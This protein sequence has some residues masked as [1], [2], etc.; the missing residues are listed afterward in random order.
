MEQQPK[1]SS[2]ELDPAEPARVGTA[3]AHRE[4]IFVFFSFR[5]HRVK[6]F[7]YSKEIFFL[8]EKNLNHFFSR[9]K[10]KSENFEKLLHGK[11]GPP[12]MTEERKIKE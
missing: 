8:F 5:N 1:L 10:L 7:L 11:P 2:P 4:K 12:Y 9:K 6:A 3:W